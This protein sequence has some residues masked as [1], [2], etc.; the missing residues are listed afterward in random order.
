MEEKLREIV[1]SLYTDVFSTGNC[2]AV[3]SHYHE[4]AICHFNGKKLPISSLKSSMCDFVEQHSE[5]K[6]TIES[7]IVDGNRTYARLTRDVTEKES[8]ERRR[9]N[10]MVEKYFVGEKIQELWFMVDDAK[11]TAMWD[12]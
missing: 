1:R 2:P 4:D 8:K 10:I 9:I 6:T 11:Y 7:L 12:R 5:I 3:D